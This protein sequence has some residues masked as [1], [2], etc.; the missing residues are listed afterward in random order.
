MSIDQKHLN[1]NTEQ[2]NSWNNLMSRDQQDLNV[3]TEQINTQMSR[4][5]QDL[6]V[7]TEQ[8]NTQMSKR[9]TR[10]KCQHWTDQHPN[11]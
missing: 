2:I 6:N 9:S 5:Q 8:I 11:V 7:N 1:I 3:N 10:P 4:D